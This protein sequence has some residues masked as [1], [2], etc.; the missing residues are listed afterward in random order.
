[1]TDR[2]Q[3]DTSPSSTDGDGVRII[4]EQRHSPG[5]SRAVK[6][7]FGVLIGTWIGYLSLR[8]PLSP[9]APAQSKGAVS[10][11]VSTPTPAG[12]S[13]RP[14]P[15]EAAT[16]V[17]A[18]TPASPSTRQPV[19][20]SNPADWRTGDANDIATYVSPTD[21][22]PTGAEL[23]KALRDSGETGGIAAFNPPGTS[24]PLRGLAVP[25]DFVLP[26]GY[27]RHHQVTD[28]GEPLEAI[29]MFSPDYVFRDAAGNPMPIPEDRVVPPE[30]A[31]PGLPI[32]QIEI[33]P[34]PE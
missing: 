7:L 1:M 27:V 28:A 19:S 9:W 17:P 24:P 13:K 4:R 33:P 22:E 34:P 8:S 25:E 5:A 23:I 31:P 14:S 32:R 3:D 11:A 15:A 18:M 26:Q 29:L 12:A 6:V 21:P 16:S 2:G 20:S 30:M 10:E